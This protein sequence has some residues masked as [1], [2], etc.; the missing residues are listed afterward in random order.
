[1]DTD[2]DFHLYQPTGLLSSNVQGIWSVSVSNSSVTGLKRWLHSDAGSGVLFNLSGSVI[3]DNDV[4]EPNAIYLPVNKQSQSIT[5]CSGAQLVGFRF[6]PAIGTAVF[7]TIHQVATPVHGQSPLDQSLRCLFNQLIQTIGH[8]RRIRLLY[9]WLSSTLTHANHVPCS[10]LTAIDAIRE[11]TQ[12]TK[13]TQG[14]H[15]NS[16]SQRQL[17][18]QFQQAIAMTPKQY[19]RLLRVKNTLAQLKQQSAMPL[20]E[21]A[22][23]NGYADQAHMTRELQHIAKITPKKYQQLAAGS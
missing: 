18:R 21:L 9:Q 17:E 14:H 6:K 15:Y 23:A 7:N 3:L 1:M 20:T 13:L 8:H 19:H 4:F 12:L 11:N 16:I 22:L 10:L 2:F 5:L